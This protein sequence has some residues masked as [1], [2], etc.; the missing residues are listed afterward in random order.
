MWRTEEAG[1]LYSPTANCNLWKGSEG[2]QVGGVGWCNSKRHK[3]PVRSRHEKHKCIV[4]PYVYAV[5]KH[6]NWDKNET[7]HE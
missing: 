6:I 4:N 2:G 5:K 3:I 7:N 1:C